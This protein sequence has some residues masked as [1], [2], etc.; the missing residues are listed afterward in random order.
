MEIVSPSARPATSFAARS[1]IS[2]AALLVK[3]MAVT[4]SGA[5]PASPVSQAIFWVMTRVLPLP[6]PASTNS[7]PSR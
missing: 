6:A 5:M 2:F 3:V 1:F 7:G 4:F